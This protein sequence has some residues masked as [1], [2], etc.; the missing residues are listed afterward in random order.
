[1]EVDGAGQRSVLQ[2]LQP[3]SRKPNVDS[4][5]IIEDRRNRVN[6]R[7]RNEHDGLLVLA[8]NF[9]NGWHAYIDGS[10]TLIYRANHSMRSVAVPAGEHVVTFVFLPETLKVSA[11][12]SFGALLFVAIGL[13]LSHYK[14]GRQKLP[15]E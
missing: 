2:N 8:D 5:E 7:T 3:G 15:Q 12:A 14:A 11:Y 13:A 9:Y 1:L 4:A 10:P 6:I